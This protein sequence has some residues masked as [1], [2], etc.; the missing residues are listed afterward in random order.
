MS[1]V[2]E[3]GPHCEL[4]Q[5]LQLHMPIL[6]ALPPSQAASSDQRREVAIAGHADGI[7]HSEAGMFSCE[8][9][10]RPGRQWLEF[11]QFYSG[12]CSSISSGPHLMAAN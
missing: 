9:G 7:S 5:L 12:I 1:E 6:E 4:S 10:R 3:P 11:L 8:A 2:A